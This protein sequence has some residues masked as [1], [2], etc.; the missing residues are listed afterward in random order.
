MENKTL[1]WK[2]L[3]VSAAIAYLSSYIIGGI[4]G[5]ALGLLGLIL[6]L[7]GIIGIFQKNKKSTNHKV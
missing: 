6:L 5:N 1:S 3:L 2:A 7:M 4:I